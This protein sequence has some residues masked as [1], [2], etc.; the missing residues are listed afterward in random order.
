MNLFQIASR[1]VRPWR[2][3]IADLVDGCLSILIVLVLLCAAMS[4]KF[5]EAD[6]LVGWMGAILFLMFFV[7]AASALCFSIYRRTR[8]SPYFDSFVCHHKADAGAQARYLQ[9]LLFEG[10]GQTCF[11]DSDHLT[12]LD[13][14]FD[15][16]RCKIGRLIVYLT[17][18]TLRRPWCAGEIIITFMTHRKATVIETLSFVPP[19]E[20]ELE[21]DKVHLYLAD[22]DVKLGQYGMTNQDMANA[23]RWLIS[24]PNKVEVSKQ[25]VGR[26][27]FQDI[28]DKVL[29][30]TNS[31]RQ[32]SISQQ[33]GSGLV[34]IS[35]APGDH[36]ALASAGILVCKIQEKVLEF[37][38]AGFLV[39]A[40][41]VTAHD[42]DVHRAVCSARAVIIML[43]R[44]SLE[45]AE[46]LQIIMDAMVVAGETEVVPMITASFRFPSKQFYDEEFG[47]RLSND[48]D[49]A[50]MRSRVEGLFKRIAVPWHTHS[51]DNVLSAQ[52]ADLI[53]R[54]PKSSHATRG[55]ETLSSR[56]VSVTGS[57][58]TVSLPSMRLI[59]RSAVQ[60][61]AYNTATT[62][63][64]DGVA[65]L[66]CD[67]TAT[68]ASSHL[69]AVGDWKSAEDKSENSVVS[70]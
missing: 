56:S 60:S 31:M 13:L 25:L 23:F 30:K 26:P 34:V 58:S 68:T 46:Q 51:S 10:S 1:Y 40:D 37:C 18:D 6:V 3:N 20:D 39:L 27:I 29:N 38:K 9:M 45:S 65:S 61:L 48:T 11:I 22:S 14:L 2:S 41:V 35:T 69:A 5:D 57:H 67:H 15:T 62:T 43:S 28:V 8:S 21:V 53:K 52:A 17:S 64:S 66:A 63:T 12:N 42:E 54:I 16:V 32:T 7:C 47:R 70:I 55:I 19:T 36:E 59:V 4:T 50:Q 44:G 33:F 49:V 24:E